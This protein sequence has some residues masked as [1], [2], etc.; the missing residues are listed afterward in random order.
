MKILTK[1][2]YLHKQ[3]DTP[4]LIVA[5]DKLNKNINKMQDLADRAG[6]KLRPHLKTHKSAWIAKRQLSAGA[7]GVTVA[8]LSEAERMADLGITDIMIANQITHPQKMGR[9]FDLNNKIKLI[10]GI[11]HPDQIP[12]LDS[13]FRQTNKKLPV[14]IEI[15]SGLHRCGVQV[16]ES[17]IKLAEEIL[18]CDFLELV[19]IFTHAGQVYSAR[20]RAEV[21][22][23]GTG[24]GKIMEE[25]VNLLQQKNIQARIVSVGS[26]P[27]APYSAFNPVVNEIRP[28]NYVFFDSIQCSLFSCSP[29]DCALFVLATVISQPANDRIVIDAGS[30]ALNLDRGAH[31]TSLVKGFGRILNVNGEI[32]RLSEEH[33]VIKLHHPEKIKIGTPLLIIPNHA[34]AVVNLYD[35]YHLIDDT[36]EINRI[37]IDS[38]GCLQ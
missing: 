30:K 32:V 33:G 9:L 34:C 13:T 29:E 7:Q 22:S 24:E 36:G 15:D 38:R 35:F 31:A 26:T 3:A 23:I 20:S 12:I 37:Q 21:K 18:N 25:A 19:G 28:G 14:S 1:I 6:V 5:Q 8:K 4:A 17:L 11:D 2:E 27:T 16:D 10:V